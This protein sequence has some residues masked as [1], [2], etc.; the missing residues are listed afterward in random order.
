MNAITPR[1]EWHRGELRGEGHGNEP[2]HGPP[3]AAAGT[4]YAT[5]PP[6]ATQDPRLT[7]AGA[8][9]AAAA[10][11]TP[12]TT[13]TQPL[14]KRPKGGSVGRRRGPPPPPPSSPPPGSTF[15][16]LR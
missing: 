10:A 11:A 14:H 2:F 16:K 3:G 7:G 4:H 6:K 15:Q 9:A 13:T 8:A 1:V 5:L 12:A